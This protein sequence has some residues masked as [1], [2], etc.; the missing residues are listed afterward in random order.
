MKPP[1]HAKLASLEAV[2][3]ARERA[4]KCFAEGLGAACGIH[5]AFFAP[6]NFHSAVQALRL[7]EAQVELAKREGAK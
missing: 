6:K 3:R 4:R 7:A 1:P 5:A 2:T